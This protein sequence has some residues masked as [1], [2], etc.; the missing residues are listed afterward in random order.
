[1]RI[2]L[3]RGKLAA[4]E[5]DRRHRRERRRRAADDRAGGLHQRRQELAVQ[6][7]HPR[8]GAGRGPAVRH[9]GPARPAG[10]TC[11]E[12]V[13]AVLT[14]TVGFIRKLPHH[15]VASFRS[16]LEEA[17]EADLVLHVVDCRPPGLDR[18]PAGG[19]GGPRGPRSE[20]GAGAGGAQ[21]DR[22]V[23]GAAPR[24]RPR[25]ARGAPGVGNDRR[26]GRRS[27]S[28]PCGSGF[29]TPKGLRCCGCRWSGRT[30]SSARSTCRTRWR[31]GF[32][33]KRWRWQCVRPPTAS[34]QK[35]SSLSGSRVGADRG[36]RLTL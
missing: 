20:T 5:R 1:M 15:L 7:A 26:G 19:R 16:T 13:T 2:S 34:R 33:T 3:L 24:L 11:G 27:C 6:R 30:W 17:T 25:G 12:G 29:S 31:G 14:D 4:I 23:A 8:R 28:K 18:A 10:R 9:A 22:P 35:V 36:A 21:Q 32:G